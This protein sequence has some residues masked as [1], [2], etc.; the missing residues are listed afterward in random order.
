M[1]SDRARDLAA[2]I[3]RDVFPPD[4]PPAHDPAEALR[5]A[6][7]RD[8]GVHISAATARALV[9]AGWRAP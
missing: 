7:W 8:A 5:N 9:R 1:T 4:A 2:S 6:F 3:L